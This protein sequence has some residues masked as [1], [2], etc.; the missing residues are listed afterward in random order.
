MA[1]EWCHIKVYSMHLLDLPVDCLY[2]IVEFCYNDARTINTYMLSICDMYKENHI[3]YYDIHMY[4]CRTSIYQLCYDVGLVYDSVICYQIYK[5]QM[6]TIRTICSKTMASYMYKGLLHGGF[7]HVCERILRIT[8]RISQKYSYASHIKTYLNDVQIDSDNVSTCIEVLGLYYTY[9]HV[10]MDNVV[11]EYTLIHSCIK[12]CISA[13]GDTYDI[14]RDILEEGFVVVSGNIIDDPLY[15][16]YIRFN[17]DM[18]YRYFH[19]IYQVMHS[20]MDLIKDILNYHVAKSGVM[21]AS[22]KRSCIENG[23]YGIMVDMK[24]CT[25]DN[26]VQSA[27]AMLKCFR[28]YATGITESFLCNYGNNHIW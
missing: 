21:G 26:V 14:V 10:L 1:Y 13:G 7:I 17:H 12:D 25:D 5:R 11:D 27:R 23:L 3:R 20:R 15:S 19:V 22:C 16:F 24:T 2:S 8:N 4:K 28:S 18:T 6:S 9:K